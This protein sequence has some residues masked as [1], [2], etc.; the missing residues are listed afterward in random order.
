MQDFLEAQYF[1]SIHNHLKTSDCSEHVASSVPFEAQVALF[2]PRHLEIT[3]ELSNLGFVLSMKVLMKKTI[4][5][6]YFIKIKESF[7]YCPGYPY[8]L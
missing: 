3:F 4:R 2:F 8:G 6:G 1:L 5:I 7:I